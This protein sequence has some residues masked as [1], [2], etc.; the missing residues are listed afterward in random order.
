MSKFFKQ[1][2]GGGA[3]AM[4]NEPI[5]MYKG[6]GVINPLTG[7]SFQSDML[8]MIAQI[9]ISGKLKKDYIIRLLKNPEVISLYERAF[10]D[11]SFDVTVFYHRC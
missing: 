10:T 4:T 3:G 2:I 5:E 1:P 6:F 9:L 8:K 11:K 7:K